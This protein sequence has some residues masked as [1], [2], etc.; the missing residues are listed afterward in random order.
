MDAEWK[1]LYDSANQKLTEDEWEAVVGH[2]YALGGVAAMEELPG[3]FKLKAGNA[4][5]DGRDAEAK[6]LREI[7]DDLQKEANRRRSQYRMKYG[8][9]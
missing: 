8:V 2:S 1:K 9:G 6:K 3:S 4:F 7:A 5:A